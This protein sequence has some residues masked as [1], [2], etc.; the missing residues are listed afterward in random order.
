MEKYRLCAVYLCSVQPNTDLCLATFVLSFERNQP[1]LTKEF[2]FLIGRDLRMNFRKRWID[3]LYRAATETQ[4]FRSTR[5]PIGLAI[6]GLFTA[7]FIVLAIF[8]DKLLV[9]PWPVQDNFS[10]TIGYALMAIG[11]AMVAWTVYYFRRS[12]GTPVPVNPPQE[13]ITSG[14]YR[15]TRNP[16]LTG[17]FLFMFGLGFAI[18]SLSLVLVFVPLYAL[19]HVWELKQI[20]EPELVKRFGDEFLAYRE[21]TPMFFP[22]FRLKE[23][24]PHLGI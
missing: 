8:V 2:P 13:L 21:R 12:R 17:V 18:H 24:F 5:T 16:M 15:H 22:R 4:K 14:L 3:Y 20:E 11:A 23:K 7:L 9:L 6:F 19:A 1:K 10:W